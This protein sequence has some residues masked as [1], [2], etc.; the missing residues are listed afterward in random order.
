MGVCCVVSAWVLLEM[1]EELRPGGSA[2]PSQM[3]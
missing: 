1:Y 2:K 3:R